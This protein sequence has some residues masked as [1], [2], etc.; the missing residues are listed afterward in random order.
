MT[1]FMMSGR[2]FDMFNN[3]NTFALDVY[4]ILAESYGWLTYQD[5]I[6]TYLVD[7]IPKG[8][9]DDEKHQEWAH[10]YE[11]ITLTQT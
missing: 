6:S 8:L 11:D 5:T 4:A 10:R 7:K 9:T 2:S 1:N 3:D